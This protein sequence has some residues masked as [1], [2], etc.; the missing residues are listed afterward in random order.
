MELVLLISLA[1]VITFLGLL[2]LLYSGLVLKP[3]RL[4]SV[5]RKQG[6]RGPSPSL[7][8]GNISEIRKSQSTTVKASTN[9]PPV[10]HNCAATLFPFFEQWRKQYGTIAK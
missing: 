10:F 7:L 2:E 4:R 9:E 3:G 5:L 6:I 1:V 8:L